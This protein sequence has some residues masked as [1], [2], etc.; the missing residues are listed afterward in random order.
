MRDL[1]AISYAGGTLDDSV[2]SDDGVIAYDHIGS[3]DAISSDLDLRA[4]LS[5][6]INYCCR[7]NLNHG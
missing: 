7:M 1:A 4:K 3:D 5:L 2:V 6:F